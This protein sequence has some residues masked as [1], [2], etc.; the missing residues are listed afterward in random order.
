MAFFP[1]SQALLQIRNPILPRQARIQKGK[2][3]TAG[4]H[5]KRR[6]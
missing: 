4:R 3:E 6:K 5:F 1:P 2:A